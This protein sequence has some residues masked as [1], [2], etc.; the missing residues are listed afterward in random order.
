[1]PDDVPVKIRLT[2]LRGRCNHRT[3]DSN[4]LVVHVDRTADQHALQAK[5]VYHQRFRPYGSL[6]IWT[7]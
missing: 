6:M 7:V 5:R 4:V 2:W 1:M 3:H